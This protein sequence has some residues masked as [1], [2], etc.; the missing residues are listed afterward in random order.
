MVRFEFLFFYIPP[1]V[2]VAMAF[3]RLEPADYEVIEAQYSKDINAILGK[4]V[5]V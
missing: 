2:A 4:V 3:D 1:K 5:I